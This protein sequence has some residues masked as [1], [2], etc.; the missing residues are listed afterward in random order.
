MV[1]AA[2]SIELRAAIASLAFLASGCL[3]APPMKLGAGGTVAI[4]TRTSAVPGGSFAASVR[5]LGA[6]PS[7]TTRSTFTTVVLVPQ[8]ARTRR[9]IVVDRATGYEELLPFPP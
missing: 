8:A 9:A 5:P 2:D 1:A 6:A 4:G 3:A 7:L